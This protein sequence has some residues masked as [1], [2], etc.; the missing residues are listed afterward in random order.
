MAGAVLEGIALG[1]EL[2]LEEVVS[3][4]ELELELV[5]ACEVVV[6]GSSEVVGEGLGVGVGEGFQV[7]VVSGFGFGGGGGGGAPD[8]KFQ[9]PYIIPSAS[10]AKKLKRP[11]EKSRPPNGHPGHSSTIW[12]CVLFPL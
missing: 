8:P 10:D 2:V 4:L 5:L 9:V 12:A 11:R 6:L 3:T 7:D 1:L